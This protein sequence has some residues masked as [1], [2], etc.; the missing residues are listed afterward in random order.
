MPDVYSQFNIRRGAAH[1][2]K[3]Q[4]GY[5]APPALCWLYRP[6]GAYDLRLLTSFVM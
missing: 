4:A 3:G 5:R 2:S 1:R 6:R